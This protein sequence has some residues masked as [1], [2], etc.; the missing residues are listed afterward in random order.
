MN[1]IR[2]DENNNVIFTVANEMNRIEI[3]IEKEKLFL[4][5]MKDWIILRL[6]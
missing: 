1:P 4:I 2:L 5:F 3:N 6:K